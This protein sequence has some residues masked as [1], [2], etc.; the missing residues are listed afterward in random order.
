MWDDL[1][2]SSLRMQG[3]KEYASSVQVLRSAGYLNALNTSSPGNKASNAS[4]T[5]QQ[6]ATKTQKPPNMLM[7]MIHAFREE[8]KIDAKYDL[9]R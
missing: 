5:M 4:S 6:N 9:R 7:Q 8:K 2:Q 3:E 1:R